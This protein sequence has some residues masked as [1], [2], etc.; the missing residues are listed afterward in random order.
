MLYKQV[1]YHSGFVG[2]LITRSYKEMMTEKP[3]QLLHWQIQKGLP[4][5][6]SRRAFLDNLHVFRHYEHSF[7]DTLPSFVPPQA[8]VD[9]TYDYDMRQEML[10]DKPTVVFHSEPT[11]PKE[12]EGIPIE[13][14]LSL[15]NSSKV[16]YVKYNLNKAQL[17]TLK[18]QYKR[19]MKRY[20]TYSFKEAK[21][22]D[23]KLHDES[24]MVN[25]DAYVNKYKLKD[26]M[27]ASDDEEYDS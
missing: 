21:N 13:E 5:T 9:S 4:K 25:S 19:K 2:G 17:Q 23:P 27:V 15:L 8:Q 12:L 6:K 26:Y 16:Q 14:D 20:R 24:F 1:K 22:R 7:M 11:L 3:E 18:N 10:D